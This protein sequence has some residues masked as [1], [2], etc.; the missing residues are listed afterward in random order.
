MYSSSTIMLTVGDGLFGLRSTHPSAGLSRRTA[1]ARAEQEQ[2][3][4]DK[5]GSRDGWSAGVE[6]GGRAEARG[7]DERA[8][9]QRAVHRLAGRRRAPHAAVG[10][11]ARPASWNPEEGSAF[12]GSRPDGVR[13]RQAGASETPGRA[14]DAEPSSVHQRTPL[15]GLA[16]GVD[17][18]RRRSRRRRRRSVESEPS[19]TAKTGSPSGKAPFPRSLD[20]VFA[21]G[22]GDAVYVNV[23]PGAIGHD[24]DLA[25]IIRSIA[26]AASASA[27]WWP[28]PISGLVAGESTSDR[29]RAEEAGRY[30]QRHLCGAMPLSAARR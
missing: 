15:P 14:L 21:R 25:V 16:G 27:T 7:P 24:A 8:A 19:N 10:V 4:L 13:R 20:E 29:R 22:R 12:D 17:F 3:L 28:Q 2:D 6:L 23:P 9:V 26:V 1:R 5:R 30:K 18:W 11:C